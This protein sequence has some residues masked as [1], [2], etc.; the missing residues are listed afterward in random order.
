ML[1]IS[2]SFIM[3]WRNVATWSTLVALSVHQTHV[4]AVRTHSPASQTQL[5]ASRVDE[6]V[7][8]ASKV[9]VYSA[10]QLYLAVQSGQ[11][12][13]E[14]REHIVVESTIFTGQAVFL[15]V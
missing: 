6:S 2:G 13:I 10:E 4:R 11:R 15:K 7:A 8:L 12:Y 9:V 5:E 14:L 3:F 1:Q